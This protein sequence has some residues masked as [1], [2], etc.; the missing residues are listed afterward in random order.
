LCQ[1]NLSSKKNSHIYPKFLSTNFLGPKGS[2]R[3]GFDLNSTKILNQKPKVI[4]DSPK[5]DYILC[6]ECEAYFSVIEGI[7]STTFLSWEDKV[8]NGEFSLTSVIK[9]LDILDC[10]SADKKTIHLFIYSIFWRASV[11]Q[12]ELFKDVKISPEFEEEIRTALM[13][14]KAINKTDYVQALNSSNNFLFYPTTIQTAKS[15]L[16]ETANILFAPL[17]YDPYSLVVDR[18][19]FM[20]FKKSKDIKNEV[21]KPFSNLTV[22]DCK[23]MILSPQLWQDAVLKKPFEL[24]AEQAIKNKK[25]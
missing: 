8:N 4:Q 9:D 6:D 17:S 12:I 19:S 25:G 10:H 14:F 2:P 18:F 22:N 3:K 23:I 15:F 1:T 21:I 7:A 24:L 20:L 5:E 13:T 16:D 11:S